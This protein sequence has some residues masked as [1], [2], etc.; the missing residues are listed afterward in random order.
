[1]AKKKKHEWKSLDGLL[2]DL[3]AQARKIVAAKEI[4]PDDIANEPRAVTEWLRE[5][6]RKQRRRRKWT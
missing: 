3:K 1:M 6:R 4:L 2:R 5:Q